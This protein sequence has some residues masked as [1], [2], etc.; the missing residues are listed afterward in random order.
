VDE[1]YTPLKWIKDITPLI[2]EIM[3]ALTI[4]IYAENAFLRWLH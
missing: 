2:V 3:I 4:L 1:K